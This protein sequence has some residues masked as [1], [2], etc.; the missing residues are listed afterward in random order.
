[1]NALPKVKAPRRAIKPPAEPA[2]KTRT[3]LCLP[4]AMLG[5]IHATM[6]AEGLSRKRRSQW[7]ENTVER[8][9]GLPGYEELI[10]EEFIDP[11]RNKTIPVSLKKP[12]RNRIDKTVQ[13]LNQDTKRPVEASALLRTAISQ[14]LLRQ[15]KR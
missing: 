2:G 9:F 10:L 6:D 11:G 1:M 7:I 4:E 13:N 3:T 12:L 5:S 15:R 8:L 14:Y